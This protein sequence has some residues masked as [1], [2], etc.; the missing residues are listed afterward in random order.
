MRIRISII[1]VALISLLGTQVSS[2]T[3]VSFKGPRPF[4][5]FVPSSYNAV[6]PVPLVIALSGYNE[7]GAQLEKYLKLTPVA[8]ADGFLYVHPD[9]SKDSHGIRFWNGTPECCN[10]YYPKVDDNAYIMS[11]I[12]QV[13]AQYSVDPNQIYI[14][15]HSNGGFLANNLA[16]NSAGRIAAIVN[17]SGG[18]YT[19][20]AACK[21]SAPISVLEIWGTK[22]ETYKI[23]HILGK[24]IPG[25]VKIFNMWGAINKCTD[26][27]ITSPEKLD[28]DTKIPGAETTIIEFQGCPLSTGIDFW[29]IVGG[30]HAPTIA[31]EFDNQVITWLLAHSKA[32]AN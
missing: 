1:L 6:N 7:T 20:A 8:Q 9:G 30:D 16:C 26:S 17:I 14:I 15:G 10:F 32:S 13:S 25:A 2:A 24:A 28:L 27:P 19:T 31:K 5:I 3:T 18:F 22:D 21:P 11:I 12:N 29:K 23:N 4:N